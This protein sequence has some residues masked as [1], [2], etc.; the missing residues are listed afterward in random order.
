MNNGFTVNISIAD[1]KLIIR[2]MIG[3]LLLEYFE[4]NN[5]TADGLLTY[6]QVFSHF[7]IKPEKLIEWKRMGL[8]NEYPK[9]KT[10]RFKMSELFQ[11]IETITSKIKIEKKKGV[12][13]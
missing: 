6:S 3:E 12:E 4:K 13:V 7:C 11:A 10:V 5:N 1:L 2:D 9:G 8:I